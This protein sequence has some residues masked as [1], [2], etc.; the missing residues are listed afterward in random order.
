L[1]AQPPWLYCISSFSNQMI[2]Y[3]E[4]EY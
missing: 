2:V 3:L 1:L 4:E